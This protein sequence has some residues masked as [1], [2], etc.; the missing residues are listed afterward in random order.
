MLLHDIRL[1]FINAM[2]FSTEFT[3]NYHRLIGFRC[4]MPIL[5]NA[6]FVQRLNKGE[7]CSRLKWGQCW[8]WCSPNAQQRSVCALY[9][10]YHNKNESEGQK[11]ELFKVCKVRFFVH[12]VHMHRTVQT[13][14]KIV[15]L[16]MHWTKETVEHKNE[17]TLGGRKG[18]QWISSPEF[19]R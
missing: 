1:P 3:F 10:W 19:I 2:F 6:S 9:L 16:M 8:V 17:W 13:N 4:S 11:V 7:F 5:F 12:T 15:E 18:L 14:I